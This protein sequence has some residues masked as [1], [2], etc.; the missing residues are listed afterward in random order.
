MLNQAKRSVADHWKGLALLIEVVD[1]GKHQSCPSYI[2]GEASDRLA[3][4]EEVVS[5]MV[6]SQMISEFAVR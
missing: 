6:V 4:G 2:A 5:R 3:N 1:C